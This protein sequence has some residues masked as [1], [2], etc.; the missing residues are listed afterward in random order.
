M[1]AH[2]FRMTTLYLF[3]SSILKRA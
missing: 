1:V 3:D 2:P